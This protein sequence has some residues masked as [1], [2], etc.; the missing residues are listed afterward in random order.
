MATEML[1]LLKQVAPLLFIDAG[2]GCL[3]G[4]CPEGAMTCGEAAAV[5]KEFKELS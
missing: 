1:R 5:R 2:P 3:R 4:S